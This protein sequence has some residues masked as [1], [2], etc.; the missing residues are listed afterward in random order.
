M[1]RARTVAFPRRTSRASRLRPTFGKWLLPERQNTRACG[2]VGFN[3]LHQSHLIKGITKSMNLTMNAK[4]VVSTDLKYICS[5]LKE[6]LDALSGHDLL[7][8]GGAGFL[9]YYLVQAGLYLNDN[10]RKN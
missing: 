2:T 5:N 9:G 7:I 3:S 6:E 8:T 1:H 4:E 10:V